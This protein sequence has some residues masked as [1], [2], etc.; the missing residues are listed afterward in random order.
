MKFLSDKRWKLIIIGFLIFGI[1]DFFYTFIKEHSIN[2][3]SI[4]TIISMTVLI[5]G[6][7][8]DTQDKSR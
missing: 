7:S 2:Y 5:F 6:F 1:I 4:V 3:M 8:N